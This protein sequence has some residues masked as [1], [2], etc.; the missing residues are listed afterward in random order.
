MAANSLDSNHSQNSYDKG[1]PVAAAA[2]TFRFA[3]VKILVIEDSPDLCDLLKC[4]LQMTGAEVEV[5]LSAS[6]AQ[7]RLCQFRANVIISDIGLPDKNGFELMC[8]VRAK[9]DRMGQKHIP[10]L[11]FSAYGSN[12]KAQAL[13]CGFQLYLVKPAP[14]MAIFGAIQELLH[15]IPA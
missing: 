15:M 10:A 7:S 8:D 2:T 12:L 6:E 11:A 4:A 14:L 1:T 3:G 9:E 5:A 13:N